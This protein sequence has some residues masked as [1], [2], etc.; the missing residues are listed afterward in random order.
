MAKR[1]LK[2]LV[3]SAEAWLCSRKRTREDSRRY[4]RSKIRGRSSAGASTRR[5]RAILAN[6]LQ[7][8]VI[9]KECRSACCHVPERSLTGRTSGAMYLFNKVA[10]WSVFGIGRNNEGATK[11]GKN[12]AGT[13]CSPEVCGN[14]GRALPSTLPEGTLDPGKGRMPG[15]GPG[16]GEPK[17]TSCGIGDCKPEVDLEAVGRLGGIP[18]ATADR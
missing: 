18:P 14:T 7:L 3:H 5:S 12:N 1:T 6:A 16:A 9:T 11:P 15:C 2:R 4:H 10:S 17:G 8:L 13:S